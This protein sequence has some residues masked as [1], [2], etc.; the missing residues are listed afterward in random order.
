MPSSEFVLPSSA[1]AQHVH[2]ICAG[3]PITECL[4]FRIEGLIHAIKVRCRARKT[5]VTADEVQALLLLNQHKAA[6]VSPNIPTKNARI[7][8]VC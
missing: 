1:L 7:H 2:E 5:G 4:A 8:T 3:A 6:C